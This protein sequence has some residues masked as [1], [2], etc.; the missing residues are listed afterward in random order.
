MSWSPV[1][2]Y[3]R[4]KMIRGDNSTTNVLYISVY[5]PSSLLLTFISSIFSLDVSMSRCALS[6]TFCWDSTPRL[7]IPHYKVELN[8]IRITQRIL[9]MLRVIEIIQKYSAYQASLVNLL[10]HF[11]PLLCSRGISNGLIPNACSPNGLDNSENPN[12]SGD[13][14]VPAKDG[15]VAPETPTSNWR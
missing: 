4:R 5:K 12:N 3:K 11:I 14:S 9:G 8:S 1:I 13:D 2:W 15:E 7:G 6:P 10:I